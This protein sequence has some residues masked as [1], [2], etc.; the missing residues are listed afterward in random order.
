M[1]SL[2]LLSVFVSFEREHVTNKNKNKSYGSQEMYIRHES[3]EMQVRCRRNT[4][5][6]VRLA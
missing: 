6:A 2:F 3:T 1:L 5:Q 4:S